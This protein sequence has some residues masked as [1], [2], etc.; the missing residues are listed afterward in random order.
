MSFISRSFQF[1][2]EIV[3]RFAR[4]Y[5]NLYEFMIIF[6]IGDILVITFA[7]TIMAIIGNELSISLRV[8]I[9]IISVIVAFHVLISII[10]L[11]EKYSQT[12]D[13]KS[14]ECK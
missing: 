12:A 6:V 14:D 2:F 4:N 1:L 9:I 13:K 8:G 5:P 7:M 10:Y 3:G 11:I